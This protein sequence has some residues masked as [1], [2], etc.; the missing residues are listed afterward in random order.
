[1]S[2]ETRLPDDIPLEEAIARIEDEILATLRQAGA[3]GGLYDIILG[4]AADDLSLLRSALGINFLVVVAL[5]FLLLAALVPFRAQWHG[6][7][8][9]VSVGMAGRRMRLA[10]G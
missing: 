10:P 8:Q 5:T 4:G 1:M 7:R 9:L 3:I 6:S 2:I